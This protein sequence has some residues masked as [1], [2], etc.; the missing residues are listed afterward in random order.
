MAEWVSGEIVL[1]SALCRRFKS[2]K[3]SRLNSLNKEESAKAAEV[4]GT[5]TWWWVGCINTR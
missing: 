2:S 5:E 3:M 4:S 1:Q